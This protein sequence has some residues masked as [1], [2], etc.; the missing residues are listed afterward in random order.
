MYLKNDNLSNIMYKIIFYIAYIPWITAWVFTSSKLKDVVHPYFIINSYSKISIIFLIVAIILRN[1]VNIKYSILGVVLAIIG[2]IVS[3]GNPNASFVF[4]TIVLLYFGAD[5][6][7]ESIIKITM[8]IQIIV[9]SITILSVYLHIIPNSAEF[10]NAGDIYRLRNDMGFTYTTFAPNYFLSIVLEYL[11]LKRK[12]LISPITLILLLI[13][14]LYIYEQTRTRLSFIFSSILL[15]GYYFLY[16]Y[17]NKIKKIY[18]LKYSYIFGLIASFLLTIMFNPSKK[19]FGILNSILSQRLRYGQLGLKLWGI[20]PFGTSVTWDTNP[21]TYNYVD[22][23]YINIAICYGWIIL[24]ITIL[25]YTL[26]MQFYAKKDIALCIILSVWAAR[27][28]IDPQLFLIWFNPFFFVV[29]I[30][31]FGDSKNK[32]GKDVINSMHIQ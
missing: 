7:L 4:Y 3:Y 29:G 27:A 25:G 5:M 10:T 18:M 24:I 30:I 12:K 22:S 6:K 13:V 16:L 23:S 28:M 32:N 20:K 1:K 14:N 17:S 26:A 9:V 11:F 21:A 19:F 2:G 8:I 31:L 15:V